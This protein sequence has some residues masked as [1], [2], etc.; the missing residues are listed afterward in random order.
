MQELCQKQVKF[1]LEND[2]RIELRPPRLRYYEKAILSGMKLVIEIEGQPDE[3]HEKALLFIF[4]QQQLLLIKE[5]ESYRVPCFADQQFW[6]QQVHATNQQFWQH[7]PL[8]TIHL[9]SL[10]SI[11]CKTASLDQHF[12]A[13]GLAQD[14]PSASPAVVQASPSAIPGPQMPPSPESLA[15]DGCAFFTLRDTFSLLSR[16]LQETAMHAVQIARW[17]REHRFCGSCGSK[18]VSSQK[19]RSKLCPACGAMYYP[20][21]SPAIIVAIRKEDKLLLLKNKKFPGKMYSVLA[22]FVEA[23]ESLEDC[24]IR[25]VYEEAGIQVKNIRYHSSQSWPFPD[26]LMVGF[27]A[28][29]AGG[30][31]RPDDDEIAD[32]RWFS[33]EELPEIP[34]PISISRHLIDAWIAEQKAR[35]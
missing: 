4:Y 19:D 2:F 13:K 18:T 33:L 32:A 12:A 23:G 14:A 7:L 3:A 35:S 31:L 29:W 28:E 22:G 26:S 9:G 30:E 10:E 11:P 27:S 25:E 17:D 15:P 21:I 24:L 6:Q 1:G 8:E 20:H 34:R 5:G 16:D